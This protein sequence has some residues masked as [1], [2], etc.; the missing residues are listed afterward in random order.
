M[1]LAIQQSLNCTEETC[2]HTTYM[3]TYIHSVYL[4]IHVCTCTY[5]YIPVES[6]V[7]GYDVGHFSG[8]KVVEK[9][10]W[11]RLLV[12]PRLFQS[13]NREG[14]IPVRFGS[15][16]LRSFPILHCPVFEHPR[17]I[18][19]NFVGGLQPRSLKH[20]TTFSSR[21]LLLQQAPLRPILHLRRGAFQ[22]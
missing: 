17:Q 2:I 3:Y 6:F 10:S 19:L 9:E 13:P 12:L 16:S 21:H 1:G 22:Q 15:H 8:P 4:H 14:D 18:Y 11:R 7:L 5:A 20:S